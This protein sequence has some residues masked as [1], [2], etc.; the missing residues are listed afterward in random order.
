[1][2]ELKHVSLDKG[3]ANFLIGPSYEEFV[4][5]VGLEG[6]EKKGC[7]CMCQFQLEIY[8]LSEA[9]REVNWILEI[10]S[11]PMYD[12]GNIFLVLYFF[13]YQKVSRRMHNS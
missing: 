4:V 2:L 11:V 7:S 3:A 12:T 8:F 10:H 6:E 13:T 5:M 9:S 1:M